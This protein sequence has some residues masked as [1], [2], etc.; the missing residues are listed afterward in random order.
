MTAPPDAAALLAAAHAELARTPGILGRAGGRPRRRRVAS[1]PGAG[2]VGAGRDR[3]SPARR[4]DGGLRRAGAG[5]RRAAASGSRRSTP[6]AGRWSGAISRTTAPA[7]WPP[8]GS[9]APPAWRFSTRSSPSG[10][11]PPRRWD[12]PV[13]CRG[14]TCWRPGSTHDRLHIAQLAATLARAW[15]DA[16]GA[17]ARGVRGP[18]PVPDCLTP[19]RPTPRR[20]AGSCRRRSSR[21]PPG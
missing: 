21:Y 13:R 10:S 15:A 14:S 6:S 3:L 20:C 4:G 1:A 16:L 11:L 9:A 17:A 18:D 5:D 19:T 8:S 2:R 7:R 12:A